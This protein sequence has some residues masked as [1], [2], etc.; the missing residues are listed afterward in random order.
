MAVEAAR[1]PGA[2]RYANESDLAALRANE[3]SLRFAVE[4][5]DVEPGRPNVIGR[6]PGIGTGRTLLYN[7]HSDTS[8]RVDGWTRDPFR[9]ETCGTRRASNRPAFARLIEEHLIAPSRTDA[10][11]DFNST[12]RSRACSSWSA[13]GTRR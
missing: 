12:A 3:R 4:V 6:L 1:I 8:P 7:G 2:P 5:M 10:A 13:I 11:G 9:G